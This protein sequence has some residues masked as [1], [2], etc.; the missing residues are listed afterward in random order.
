M[1]IPV[2]ML[3]GG[4]VQVVYDDIREVTEAAHI[5]GAAVK[6]ILEMALLTRYEKILG[7]LL[8]QKAGVEY[9][10]TSTGFGPG[11]ATVEDVEL[12][13]CVVGAEMG[14]KAAGG[15]RSLEDARAMLAA[16][17][18]RLG[19]SSGVKIVQQEGGSA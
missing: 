16:G 3:K 15:V 11:G 6:V 7:C 5:L 9:V 19:S 2:G 17:A 8:C 12:M 10:K 13:R 4:Q 1:V 18:T 14:I